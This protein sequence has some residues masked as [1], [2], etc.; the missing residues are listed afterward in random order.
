M[1]NE[2]CSQ[3]LKR[4]IL[5]TFG[6]NRTALR[7]THPKLHS[8]FCAL[9][10]KVALSAAELM[11]EL[12]FDTVGDKCYVGKPF[13]KPLVKFMCLKIE[14]IVIKLLKVDLKLYVVVLNRTT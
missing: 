10:L 4:S 12:L 13:V 3:K 5:A 1:L 7:A 6:F 14:P 11:S 9:F 2:F 8:M